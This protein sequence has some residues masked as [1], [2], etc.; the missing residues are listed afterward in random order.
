MLAAGEI[1]E[2]IIEEEGF[3]GS[4]NQVGFPSAELKEHRERRG[5]A[6]AGQREIC[7]RN[8]GWSASS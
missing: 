2:N 5:S 7:S 8:I 1:G 6:M 3:D 4:P